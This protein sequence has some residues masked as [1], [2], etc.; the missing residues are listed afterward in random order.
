MW[1]VDVGCPR[2]ALIEKLN[3]IHRY[4]AVFKSIFAPTE[5]FAPRNDGD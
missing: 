2:Q 5:K 3:Y 4:R 1:L